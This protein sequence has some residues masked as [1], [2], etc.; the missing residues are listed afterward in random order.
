MF[1]VDPLRGSSGSA[2]LMASHPPKEERV[3]RLGEMA[4]PG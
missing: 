1:I 4:A 3:R 2:S